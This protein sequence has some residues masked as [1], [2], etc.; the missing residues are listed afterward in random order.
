MHLPGPGWAPVPTHSTEARWAA[1]SGRGWLGPGSP[2]KPCI[3]LVAIRSFGTATSCRPRE[4]RAI[5]Q[6]HECATRFGRAGRAGHAGTAWLSATALGATSSGAW[7]QLA[8]SNSVCRSL[9]IHAA[10][11]PNIRRLFCFHAWPPTL[12]PA[13][14]REG[15]RGG[16]AGCGKEGRTGKAGSASAVPL[17]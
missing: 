13:V 3:A 15:G 14:Q 2:G 16:R 8:R 9:Q 12:R 5:D 1:G 6:W 7:Q 11:L 10:M 4:C 17:T